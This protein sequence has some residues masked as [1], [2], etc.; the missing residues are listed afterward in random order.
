MPMRI[1]VVTPF[2]APDLGPSASLYAML[3]EDLAR[4]GNDVTVICAVPHYPSGCVAEPFRGRLVWR[5]ERSG[6]RIIR[7]WV[8][9]VNRARLMLRLWSL[10]CYQVLAAV[11]VLGRKYDVSIASGPAFEVALPVVAMNLRRRPMIYS[12]HEIYP[13]VGIKA[14]VF[15]RR[16]AIGLVVWLESWC[17]ARAGYVRVLSE[18]YRRALED[19]G[20]ASTK[21]QVI[22]DW[23]DTDFIS[24]TPRH[25]ALS[26]SWDLDEHFVVMHAGNLGLTQGLEHVVEAAAGLVSDPRICFVFVGDGAARENLQVK[27]AGLSNVRFIPFQPRSLLPL[28]LA[29]GDVHLNSLK[30]GF[31]TDSVPSKCYSIMAAGRPIVAAVDHDTDSWALVQQ[32]GCGVCVPPENPTALAHAIRELYIDAQDRER[33][34]ANGRAYVVK[35]HSRRA[36]TGQ[37]CRLARSLASTT[38]LRRWKIGG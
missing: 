25:N 7:L 16:W 5:E 9:S 31:A 12:V 14:G 1:L 36:A 33:L 20:V 38:L 4:L 18:G 29:S 35:H 6:V 2:Y 11:M 27:A 30:R 26:V 32:A 23:V 10:L 15:R 3:S 22:G 21:L 34:G 28:V 19:R 37:F 24:P 17:C 8:P 13:D